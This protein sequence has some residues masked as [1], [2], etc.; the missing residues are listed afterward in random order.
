MR[1]PDIQVFD[2]PYIVLHLSHQ[3]MQLPFAKNLHFGIL[4]PP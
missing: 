3:S 2:F 1:Y 4:L